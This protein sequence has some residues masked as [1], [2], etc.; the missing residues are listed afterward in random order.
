M[1]CEQSKKSVERFQLCH[2]SFWMCW[3]ELEMILLYQQ[4]QW[5]LIVLTLVVALAQSIWIMLAVQEVKAAWLTVHVAHL[6]P[7]PMGTQK[8]LEWGAKVQ[9][10]TM[11][12][13]SMYNTALFT[14]CSHFHWQLHLWWCTSGGRFQSVWGQSGGV[15]Q[16]SVGDSVWWQL[17]HHWCYCGLQAA[18]ICLHWKWV[19]IIITVDFWIFKLMLLVN[20]LLL[21]AGRAYSN[22]RF[23]A[24]SGPIH[25]DNVD[26]IGSENHLI[27]CSHANVNRCYYGHS[28]DAGVRC[29]GLEELFN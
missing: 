17:G 12:F 27:N 10:L 26:C 13:S 15:H 18:G 16:W 5:P 3:T 28:E 22:A 25:L 24:G 23:G 19:S 7:V 14:H 8:M 6:S 21:V 11:I 2:S 20:C 9:I 29:Q 1:V 4:I